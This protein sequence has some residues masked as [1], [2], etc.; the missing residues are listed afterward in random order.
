[1]DRLTIAHAGFDI[2]PSSVK[3]GRLYFL[4]DLLLETEMIDVARSFF[5]IWAAPLTQVLLSGK[6]YRA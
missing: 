5:Q 2:L 4:T 6:G 1:M 3:I